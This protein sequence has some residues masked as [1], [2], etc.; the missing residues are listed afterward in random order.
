[1]TLSERPSPGLGAAV[2]PAPPPGGRATGGIAR[3]AGINSLGNVAS[4]VLGVLRES[5]ISGRFGASG[6][7]SAFDAVSAVPKMVYELL[8]GGMLSAAL[9]PVLSEYTEDDSPERH[10]ELEE[11]LSILLSLSTGIFV[12]VTAALLVGAPWLAPLLVGG[13]DAALL[14]TTTLLLRLIVPAIIIYGISGMLQ[15]YHY[16]RQAFVY[17][18]MGAPAHNLG[19]ILAVWV[20]AGRFDIASLSVSILVGALFQLLVQIPGMRGVRLR[21]R[22]N[23]RHPVIRRIGALYAPVVLSIAIQNL[24]IIIDRNFASRTAPEAITWMTKATFLVQ[25]PL[26]LVSMAIS[27]AVLPTLSQ[28]DAT[29]ELDAF[30][31]TL[32]RGLRLVLVLIIPAGVGLF[33][34]GQPVIELIFQ[35]GVFTPADTAQALRALRVYLIGL[36]FS[37]ID[38]P[39]VFAFYAQKDTRTPVMVGIVAVLIYLAVAPLLAFALNRGFIGLVAANA[40]QWLAHAVIML[41]VF[42]RRFGGMG[43]Y[44]VIRA[45][46]Q[47]GGASLGMGLVAFG[48]YRLILQLAPAG[49]MG[50][51]LLAAVP[52]SLGVIVFLALA[53]ALHIDEIDMLWGMLGRR[54]GRQSGATRS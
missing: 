4:R 14:Q 20:L 32:T 46:L 41:V 1:M 54:L 45:T 26:G 9:V 35:H 12:I 23:W 8:V 40:V 34:L 43:G 13:F 5:V 38:L 3:A 47:A 15:A 2:P 50:S 24:G 10:A 16:A 27:L 11:V 7:T 37:A 31:R 17:P 21:W 6:A 48:A 36:P 42:A 52:A 39:L 22:W 53:R 51:A 30:K 28:M 49:L 33:V 19:I 18:S 44:G 25:L 29:R